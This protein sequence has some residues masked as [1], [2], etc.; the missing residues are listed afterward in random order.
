MNSSYPNDSVRISIIDIV[1]ALISY[2]HVYVDVNVSIISLMRKHYFVW[3]CIHWIEYTMK[4]DPS[5]MWKRMNAQRAD[6]YFA[7]KHKK[8]INVIEYYRGH[9]KVCK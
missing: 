3:Y 8:S 7:T 9:L 4:F 2:R 6:T 1:I 5:M